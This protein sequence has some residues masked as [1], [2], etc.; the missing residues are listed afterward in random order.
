MKVSDL[1]IYNKS[2][3]KRYQCTII[4]AYKEDFYEIEFHSEFDPN[5]KYRKYKNNFPNFE[6]PTS[7]YVTLVRGKDIIRVEDN[8]FFL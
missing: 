2:L 5:D 4:G 6:C 7:N 8:D 1:V 3:Y